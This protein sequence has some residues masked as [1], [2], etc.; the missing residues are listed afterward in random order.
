MPFTTENLLIIIGA[1][2]IVFFVVQAFIKIVIA[3]HKFGKV[4][5]SCNL[6]GIEIGRQL[7]DKNDLNTTYILENIDQFNS[8]YDVN[9]KLIRLASIHFNGES[10]IDLGVTA[11]EVGYALL[12]K[13]N[14]T[15]LKIRNFLLP[16]IN[17]IS[18]LGYIMIILTIFG[19][20]WTDIKTVVIIFGIV[21]FFHLISLPLEYKAANKAKEQLLKLKLI[22]KDE[23]E[24][25][26]LILDAVVYTYIASI[27]GNI[28]NGIKSLIMYNN[29]GDR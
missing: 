14:N 10:L 3:K 23:I 18:Y 19:G 4:K 8:Y 11:H 27:I 1:I 24:S 15:Y 6:S 26:D 16:I 5:S 7:L 21:L 9:K 22:E 29:R 12:D 28:I 2:I 25:V 17:T 13:A 20:S